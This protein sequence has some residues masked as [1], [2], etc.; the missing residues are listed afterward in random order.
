[1]RGHFIPKGQEFIWMDGPALTAFRLGSRLVL[2]EIDK[3]SGDA[4]TF[5]HALLDDPGIARITLPTG[6]TVIPHEDFHVIA[7]MNGEPE[8]LPDALRD[9]FAVRIHIDKLH[10]EA[11]EAL[12]KDLHKI[13]RKGIS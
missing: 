13:A 12:P 7:T 1:L 4:L 6:E 3:A 2:N 11:V 8:D 5:C 9:R 10:P